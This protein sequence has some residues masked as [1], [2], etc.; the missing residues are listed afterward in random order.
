VGTSRTHGYT[1]RMAH[2]NLQ[3]NP[4]AV[5]PAR[6]DAGRVGRVPAL[7]NWGLALLT[8]PLAVVVI[9]VALGGVMSTS[10]CSGSACQ[11]PG[12]LGFGVLLF[13]APVVA[14]A[15][16]VASFFTTR[17]RWGIAVPLVGLALI[18]VDL[19]VLAVSF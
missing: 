11:G 3:T 15:T 9:F 4:A 12:S 10:A 8:V 6:H 14:V 7:I 19:I 17:R 2:T 1:N 13:G 16:I 18:A 5:E